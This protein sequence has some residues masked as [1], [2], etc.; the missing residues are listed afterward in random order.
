MTPQAQRLQALLFVAGEAV[1]RQ[2]L[3][4]LL[5][6]SPQELEQLIAELET[7]LATGGLRLVQ[8]EREVELTTSGDVAVWLAQFLQESSG[9]LSRAAA[10][11]LAVVAYTGPVTRYEVD[12][13]RGVDSRRMLRQLVQRGVIARL[14]SQGRVR[15][16]DVTEEFLK[17]LGI[18]QRE[19]LPQFQEFKRHEGIR[20]LLAREL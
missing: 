7:E 10:E 12:M 5:A 13:L 4:T 2:E 19:A 15:R 3:L 1:S 8:T 9:Q 6:A 11:T 17:Q 20:R 16:Y 14:P 18:T